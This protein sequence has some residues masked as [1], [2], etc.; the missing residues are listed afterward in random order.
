MVLSLTTGLVSP[1]YHL[2][3]DEIFETIDRKIPTPPAIRR[4]KAGLTRE[5]HG[6]TVTQTDI[7]SEDRILLKD[8]TRMRYS[9]QALT[10]DPCPA[11]QTSAVQHLELFPNT[12]EGEK[13]LEH[14]QANSNAGLVEVTRF[15]KE[16]WDLN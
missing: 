13:L 12:S 15:G 7:S 2:V 1:Q 10:T 4:T 5:T 6:P 16:H 9:H 14:S 11:D 8:D 3:H